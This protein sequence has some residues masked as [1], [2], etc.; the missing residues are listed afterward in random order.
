MG[1][2]FRLVSERHYLEIL[3][4]YGITRMGLRSL[5]AALSIPLIFIGRDAFLDPTVFQFAMKYLARAGAP[6]FFH[7]ALARVSSQELSPLRRVESSRSS[8]SDTELQDNWTR[9]ANDILLSRKVQSLLSSNAY[10]TTLRSAG[11]FMLRASLAHLPPVASTPYT[12]NVPPPGP[13]DPETEDEGNPEIRE[14]PLSYG[15]PEPQPQSEQEDSS[16]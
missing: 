7:P 4:P 2:G 6:D 1:N 9:I 10:K 12:S 16:H 5:F 3:G 13:F 14:E 11:L 15:L 8:L